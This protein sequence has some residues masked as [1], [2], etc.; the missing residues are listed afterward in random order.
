MAEHKLW[1]IRR[2]AHDA[3]IQFRHRIMKRRPSREMEIELFRQSGF[4][5]GAQFPSGG[6]SLTK[7]RTL[8]STF[9][10]SFG[11]LTRIPRVGKF[12]KFLIVNLWT[13]SRLDIATAISIGEIWFMVPN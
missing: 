3:V 5:N 2:I 10:A 11:A 7:T 13:R 12:F 4:M 6:T 8:L 1:V 9:V